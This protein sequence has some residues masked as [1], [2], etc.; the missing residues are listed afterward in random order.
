VE[1]N[2]TIAPVHDRQPAILAPRDYQQYLE[3]AE[4]PSIH[5][6]RVFR[7]DEMRVEEIDQE[8]I[9]NEQASLFDGQ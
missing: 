4:R 1:A 6:L 9:S 7:D 5:L 2:E 8:P 3:N